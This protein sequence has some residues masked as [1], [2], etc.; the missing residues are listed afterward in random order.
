MSSFRNEMLA[1]R[2][3]GSE[4]SNRHLSWELHQAKAPSQ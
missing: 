3:S 1:L 2:V 4:R